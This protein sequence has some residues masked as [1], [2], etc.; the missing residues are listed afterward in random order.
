MVHL[1]VTPDPLQ[2]YTVLKQVLLASHEMPDF[3]RVE[4]LHAMEPRG[5]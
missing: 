5:G 3:Q 1:V 4:M 2:P